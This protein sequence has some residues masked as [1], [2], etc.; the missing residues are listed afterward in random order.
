MKKIFVFMTAT[1][2]TMLSIMVYANDSNIQAVKVQY[3]VMIDN[4]PINDDVLIVSIEDRAYVPI[5]DM[6]GM[7]N[8]DVCWKDEG[9]I[10]ITTTND[11]NYNL[12]E[13]VAVKIADAIFSEEFGE[14]YIEQT[15]V[16][17]TEKNDTYEI[18]RNLPFPVCG[19]DSLIIISKR[20]GRIVD[21]EIY[22]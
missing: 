15:Q 3:P 9:V 22:E 6:C 21:F 20:D 10:E 2:I 16:S 11:H 19:G 17:I 18:Y 12:C 4:T 1:I 7:L 14:A 8:L 13:D 5:R